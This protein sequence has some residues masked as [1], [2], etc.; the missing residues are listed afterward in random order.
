MKSINQIHL[1]DELVCRA[2][3]DETELPDKHRRHLAECQVCRRQVE[4][5]RTELFMLGEQARQSVEPMKKTV[6]LPAGEPGAAG[7]GS[8]WLPSLGA[9]VM[10]G[11]VLFVYFLRVETT[12][13]L[14]AE[15]ESQQEEGIELMLEDEKLMNEISE[16]VEYPLPDVMYELTGENRGDFDEFLQFAVPVDQEDLQ[17]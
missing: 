16:M 10:A 9:A 7:F 2:V 4:Q 3:V 11:V 13:P 17:S 8:G 1:D 6:L 5:L 15:L 12:P 14:V